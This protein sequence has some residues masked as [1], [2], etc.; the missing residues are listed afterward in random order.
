ML[1]S[2]DGPVEKAAVYIHQQSLIPVVDVKNPQND[3]IVPWVTLRN[4]AHPVV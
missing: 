2:M 3:V 1:L 4:G